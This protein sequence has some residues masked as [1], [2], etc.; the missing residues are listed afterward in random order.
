MWGRSTVRNA[1]EKEQV[2][3]DLHE[4]LGEKRAL[5][6]KML[7][8]LNALV[9]CYGERGQGGRQ[10]SV[11]H[12]KFFRGRAHGTVSV[13]VQYGSA[14]DGGWSNR[15]TARTCGKR[16]TSRSKRY[17]SLAIACLVQTFIPESI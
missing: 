16:A 15:L 11:G 12:S 1:K 17:V 7:E 13:P 6:P 3:M 14:G 10:E 4:V 2:T 9:A 8:M 5:V